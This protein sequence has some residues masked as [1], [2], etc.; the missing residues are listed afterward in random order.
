MHLIETMNW[1]YDE[2]YYMV[3]TAKVKE[4]DG[5]FVPYLFLCFRK[6]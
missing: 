3:S 2:K 6:L 1:T 5:A 4:R